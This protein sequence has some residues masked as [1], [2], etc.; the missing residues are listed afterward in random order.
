MKTLN[1]LGLLSAC[2]FSLALGTFGGCAPKEERKSGDSS[3]GPT[4]PKA[5][6]QDVEASGK[7]KRESPTGFDVPVSALPTRC[8]GSV[9]APAVLKR[10]TKLELENKIKDVFPGNFDPVA[11]ASKL[12]PDQASLLGF[13]N[14]ASL[15]LVG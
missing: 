13:T 9:A 8:G 4:G 11:Y 5:S 7:D 15:L 14:N 1:T 3:T 2:A 10:L 12:S 6:A